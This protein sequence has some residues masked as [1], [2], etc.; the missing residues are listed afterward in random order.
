MKK[1]IIITFILLFAGASLFAQKPHHQKDEHKKIKKEYKHP[2]HHH[3][4][5][6]S[7]TVIL[8]P[9]APK[10]LLVE[11]H[12]PSPPRPPSFELRIPAPPPPPRPPR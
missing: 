6:K 4:Y 1:K 12:L 7:R 11:I 8:Q 9:T 2:Y 3:D 10:P 5:H